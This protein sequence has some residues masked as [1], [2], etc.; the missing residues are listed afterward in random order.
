MSHST[1]SERRVELLDY[2]ARK[3]S[4]GYLVRMVSR[5]RAAS[6]SVPKDGASRAALKILA[7]LRSSVS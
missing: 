7:D 6:L 4:F 2:E 5:Y 1:R 3:D